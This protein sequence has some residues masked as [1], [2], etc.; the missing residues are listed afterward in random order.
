MITI[1]SIKNRIKN[2]KNNGGTT[3]YMMDD[4]LGPD[5]K[6]LIVAIR[7]FCEDNQYGF[8][9]RQCKRCKKSIYDIIIRW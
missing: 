2:I 5:H 8:E 3:L 7:K 9:K 4:D 1:D 6:V